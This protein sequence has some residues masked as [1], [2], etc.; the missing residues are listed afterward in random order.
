MNDE[1]AAAKARY[2]AEAE[3]K[4]AEIVAL[5]EGV[6]IWCAANREE[7]TGGGKV[8]FHA[9]TSGEVRWRVTPPKVVIKGVE[10][11]LT[12]L[13]AAG[14][15]QFIRTKEEISKEAILGDD[16]VRQQIPGI[17]IQQTEEFVVVPFETKLEEVA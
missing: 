12:A 11:V 10:M 6:N 2:E 1:I 3:P 9:F 7:L 14:L 13:K 17:S 16:T 15:T 8:K 4:K 5:T